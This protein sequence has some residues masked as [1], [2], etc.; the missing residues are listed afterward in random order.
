M[1][2]IHCRTGH[3]ASQTYFVLKHLLNYQKVYWYDAGWSEWASRSE[4][5]VELPAVSGKEN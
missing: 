4:L 5:P 2:I 3:Q 1:V